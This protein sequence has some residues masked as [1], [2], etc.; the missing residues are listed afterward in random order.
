MSES[1]IWFCGKAFRVVVSQTLL[2]AGLGGIVG[3]FGTYAVR[4][5]RHRQR[6]RTQQARLRRALI[7]EMA[8]MTGLTRDRDKISPKELPTSHIVSTVVFENNSDK[9]GL[10]TESETEALIQFYSYAHLVRTQLDYSRSLL[11]EANHPEHLDF[12]HFH[13]NIKKLEALWE[14]TLKELLANSSEMNEV[15]LPNGDGVISPHKGTSS[16]D[17]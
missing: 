6:E 10:L 15:E 4:L 13:D 12:S 3:A 17:S 16:T 1:D 9:I 11:F 8:T 2:A 7:A 5:L 14:A